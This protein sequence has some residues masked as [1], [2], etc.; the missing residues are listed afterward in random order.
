MRPGLPT[1]TRV[2]QVSSGT[3]TPT[4]VTGRTVWTA[5]STHSSTQPRPGRSQSVSQSG[6]QKGSYIILTSPDIEPTITTN[7]HLSA[8][9]YSLPIQRTCHRCN[10]NLFWRSFY[11]KILLLFIF[12]CLHL[13]YLHL[14]YSI[15]FPGGG[16]T[17]WCPATVTTGPS[18]DPISY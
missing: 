2:T 1:G 13:Y 6:R 5:A 4:S 7:L 17:P 14:V 15:L 18:S 16:G 9:R 12:A 3:S 8:R 11:F 10:K